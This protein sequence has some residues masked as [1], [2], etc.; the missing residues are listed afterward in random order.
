MIR[1]ISY[2][3]IVLLIYSCVSSNLTET[4]AVGEYTKKI[5]S[6]DKLSV[7]YNLILNADNFFSLSIKI[8]DAN[9]KCNGKWE[10][11]DN[12]IY[13]K[14]TE[15]NNVIEMLSS[16]YMK[17]KEYHLEVINR[18]KIKFENVILKRK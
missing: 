14:C 2:V 16:G 17:K 7:T 13:L 4:A 12:H 15:S 8:Q 5:T 11:K 6:K 9:P 18:N 1:K 10:L 3:L